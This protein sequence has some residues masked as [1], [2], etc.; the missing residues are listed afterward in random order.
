[1]ST[2]AALKSNTMRGEPAA[3][4]KRY[5]VANSSETT[6]LTSLRGRFH[7]C[8]QQRCPADKLHIKHQKS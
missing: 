2:G 7:V 8:L 6:K 4:G 1:M 3:A 5:E